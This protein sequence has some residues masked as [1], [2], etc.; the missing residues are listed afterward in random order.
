MQYR[1]SFQ[2][3]SNN[4]FSSIIGVV[5]GVLFLLG[6][7]FVARIIFTILYYLSPVM[8]IA[9]LIIDYKSV[10]GYGKW[11]VDKVK[12]NPLLGIG[13]I[14]LTVLAFPLVSL[15]LLGKALFK[16]KVREVEQE[17]ERQREGEYVD[18]EEL[19]SE[20]M[21]LKRLEEQFREQENPK[22]RSSNY[23]DFFDSQS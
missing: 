3:S 22:R 15:F 2:T 17:V 12:T 10:T 5:L 21:D 13:G 8:L 6:L 9:A 20:P 7:F 23:D 1:K 16:K 18:F 14:L 19:D 4:P 11:L